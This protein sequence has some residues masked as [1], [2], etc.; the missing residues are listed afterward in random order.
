MRKRAVPI[1]NIPNRGC[2]RVMW[3]DDDGGI[4]VTRQSLILKEE[5]DEN[6]IEMY[7]KELFYAHT[8]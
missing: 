2:R 6:E 8:K 7:K 4:R 1:G 3:T 5:P